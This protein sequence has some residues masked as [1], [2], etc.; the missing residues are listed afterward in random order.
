MFSC[1]IN[2]DNECLSVLITSAIM[3][4]KSIRF[5]VSAIRHV[6]GQQFFTIASNMSKQI[7]LVAIYL[8]VKFK[9]SL[10]HLD[11]SYF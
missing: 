5:E 6:G 11:L 10:V 7:I 3:Y 4:R 9:Q 1:W 2:H 8:S